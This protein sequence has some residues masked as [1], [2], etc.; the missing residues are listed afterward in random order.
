MHRII[1]SNLWLFC[2]PLI[3][4]GSGK[5]MFCLVCLGSQ[6]L[7]AWCR[8]QKNG[9]SLQSSDDLPIF[10][11]AVLASHFTLRPRKT[12]WK[13]RRNETIARLAMFTS[14]NYDILDNNLY[15]SA[16]CLLRQN[17]RKHHLQTSKVF[18]PH[19][20]TPWFL[21]PNKNLHTTRSTTPTCLNIYLNFK[22]IEAVLQQNIAVLRETWRTGTNPLQ[23]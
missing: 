9:L 7:S 19:G 17:H 15:M 10:W 23:A 6:G 14:S 3:S 18:K 5:S 2:L 13:K 16:S 11:H 12:K 4:F 8:S 21:L 1:N 22:V 20:Q